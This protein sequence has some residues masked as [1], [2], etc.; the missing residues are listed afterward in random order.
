MLRSSKA[1]KPDLGDANPI[2]ISAGGARAL[3]EEMHSADESLDNHATLSA[4]VSDLA[5]QILAIQVSL[6]QNPAPHRS[7]MAFSSPSNARTSEPDM[8]PP[9]INLSDYLGRSPESNPF[10]GSS[11]QLTL[12]APPPFGKRL[13]HLRDI[14]T[15]WPRLTTITKECQDCSL[16]QQNTLFVHKGYTKPSQDDSLYFRPAHSPTAT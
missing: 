11:P 15:Y 8:V 13:A 6:R 10:A 12:Q 7:P 14:F 2:A 5:A 1:Y 9:T 16:A 4:Q 3:P